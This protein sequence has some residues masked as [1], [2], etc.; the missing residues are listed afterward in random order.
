MSKPVTTGSRL[1]VVPLGSNM[2]SLSWWGNYGLF[3]QDADGKLAFTQ[4]YREAAAASNTLVDSWPTDEF[5]A[6]NKSDE[7]ILNLINECPDADFPPIPLADGGSFAAF[8]TSRLDS[9]DGLVNT[10]VLY[11]EISSRISMV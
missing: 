3:Y 8:T 9:R 6:E 1:A 2:T 4:P 7:S 5:A 10:Y 11:Q